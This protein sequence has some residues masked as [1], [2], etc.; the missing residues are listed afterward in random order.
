MRNNGEFLYLRFLKKPSAWVYLS[1]A[2]VEPVA[3]LREGEMGDPADVTLKHAQHLTGRLTVQ[4]H[5]K[6]NKMLSQSSHKDDN[7]V[8]FYRSREES[9]NLRPLV[10]LLNCF[11]F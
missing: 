3:V 8:Y 6:Q 9:L 5:W 11:K 1:P 10:C 4:G 7:V 2:S